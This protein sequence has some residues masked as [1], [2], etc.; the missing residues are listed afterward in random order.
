MKFRSLHAGL[1]NLFKELQQD[2][3]AK[4]TNH[5]EI[6]SKEEE[7]TLWEKKIVGTENTKAL[8]GAV[9]YLNGKNLCLRGGQEYCN[10]K[11]SQLEKRTSP[12]VH[13]TV[14]TWKIYPKK[15]LEV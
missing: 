9:F 7:M 12:S 6:T 4:D 3:V 1:D 15:I 11:L 14:C 10:L 5:T 8:L 2:G 13:Y